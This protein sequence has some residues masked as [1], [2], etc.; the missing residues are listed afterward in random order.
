[1][2]YKSTFD[3]N[4][5]KGTESIESTQFIF[6]NK[7]R[8]LTCLKLRFSCMFFFTFLLSYAQNGKNIHATYI[9]DTLLLNKYAELE[10]SFIEINIDSS[11]YYGYKA[12]EISKKLNQPYYQGFFLCDLAYNQMNK[13]DYS[14][15]FKY[16]MEATRISE[17]QNLSLNIIQ[18][19]FI[20]TYIQKDAA[21]N[22]KELIGWIKNSLGILYGITGSPEKKLN[23]LIGAKKLVE[24]YINDMFLLAGITSNIVSEYMQMGKLDSALYY[25]RQVMAFESKT[26]RQIYDGASMTVIGDIYLQEGKIDSA[27]KYLF[28]AINKL[29]NRGEN[30]SDLANTS[31]SLSTLYYNIN[32][33]DSGIYYAKSAIKSYNATGVFLTGVLDSYTNLALNFAKS[34]K[35]DSAYHYTSLSKNL[36]DSLNTVQIENLSKFQR[37]AFDEKLDQ[38]RKDNEVVIAANRIRFKFLLGIILAFSVIAFILFRNYKSKIR[39][40]NKLQETL[41][42]LKSTQSQLIQSEKMA[43]LGELTAGI[44]HEI[45]NPLNF[46]NNFSEIS[47]ELIEEMKVEL[48][49]GDIVEA[50]AIASDISLN[51]EK[52]NHHGKRADAIVKGMLQHS[53]S[54]SGQKEPTDINALCDEYLRLSYHGLRAKDKSFNATLKTDFDERIASVNIIPQDIGRVVLNLLTNAFYAVNERKGAL[55]ASDV[56]VSYI[57]T[58]SISTKKSGNHIE[59]KIQDNGNGIPQS[60]IDKIFQPFFTTKPTGQ[61]TGLGLSLSYDIITKGHGGELKVESKEGEGS[62]F[63][64]LLPS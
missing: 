17:D 3:N 40:N 23:E 20:Q 18:T 37:V 45:Q 11:I 52:I 21:S 61:G 59:I 8:M 56:A 29:K 35:Y 13:G 1:M 9:N 48:T 30:L 32:Q 33:P 14:S 10:T 24:P 42:D 2:V 38:Q 57:P 16:L 44:A 25:Q 60:A 22:R 53:R 51:L 31:N 28:L 47:N 43:S 27:K 36:S 39:S 49:N 63:T 6:L 26:A 15:A 54:N 5:V 55:P 62:S 64:I 19:P 41:D 7:M 58:V 46:V 4:I 12:L 50:I 34:N